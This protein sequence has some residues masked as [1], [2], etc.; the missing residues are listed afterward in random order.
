MSS[1]ATRESQRIEELQSDL[2]ESRQREEE[3]T[4]TMRQLNDKIRELEGVSATLY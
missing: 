2:V 3:G 4:S 1:S